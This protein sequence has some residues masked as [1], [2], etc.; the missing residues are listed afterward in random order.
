M[1]T[2]A[3]ILALGLLPA[4][5]HDAPSGWSYPVSCCSGYD[6]REVSE[7]DIIEG[8]EGYVIR[9]TGEVIPMTSRKVRPSPDGVF[10]WCSVAGKNDGKTICLFVPPR[11]Y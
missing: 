11:G 1:S 7:T 6:C 9:V 8:P 4:A 2:F 3:S 10:H 5:A